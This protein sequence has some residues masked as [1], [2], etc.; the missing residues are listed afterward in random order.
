MFANHCFWSYFVLI[1]SL[2]W[3]Y[4]DFIRWIFSIFQRALHFRW[5]FVSGGGG[6]DGDDDDDDDDDDDGDDM[7]MMMVMMM[8]MMMM[9]MI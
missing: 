3:K 9:M 8:M 4:L 5:L 6:D 1:F 2:S 7:M